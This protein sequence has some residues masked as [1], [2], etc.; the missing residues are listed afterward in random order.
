V[1]Q[2]L[3]KDGGQ[4]IT[5][6]ELSRALRHAGFKRWELAVARLGALAPSEASLG[7]KYAVRRMAMA[8]TMALG[9]AAGI[10]DA[11][12]RQSM[13][14]RA[15]ATLRLLGNTGGGHGDEE[16]SSSSSSGGE[17]SSDDENASPRYGGY[18]ISRQHRHLRMHQGQTQAVPAADGASAAG[19]IGGAVPGGG[20]V[21]DSAAAMG[22][23]ARKM[24]RKLGRELKETVASLKAEVEQVARSASV[25]GGLGGMGHSGTSL[26]GPGPS[27]HSGTAAPYGGIPRGPSG[28][29]VL[30]MGGPS[31][32]T[33][34][35]SG[36]R[37]ESSLE[38]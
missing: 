7:A 33:R 36:T 16:A 18:G 25:A 27:A 34:H 30:P 9:A 6:Q 10:S 31:S 20:G 35:G 21:L 1:Q 23:L 29:G 24:A 15:E 12:R 38:D 26:A 14:Q 2:A 19:T 5:W 28:S 32:L 13:T 17:D 4:V 22:H 3:L 8:N 37:R 11:A